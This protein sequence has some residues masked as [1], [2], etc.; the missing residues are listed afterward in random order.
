MKTV[1]I[2]LFAV[3]AVV[4]AKQSYTTKFDSIDLDAILKNPRLV[5]FYEK[6]LLGSGKC[7]EEG[8]VLKDVI[9]DALVTS[10][11][12]CNEIQRKGV[13]KVIRFLIRE[14]PATWAA[15]LAK[16]DPKG[17]YRKNYQKYLDE[18]KH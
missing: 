7:N 9:P 3:L 16:Y 4:A 6:C 17:T 5:T 11:T 18:I 13:E 8:N 1:S 12:K 15:F 2:V 14:R 10:C